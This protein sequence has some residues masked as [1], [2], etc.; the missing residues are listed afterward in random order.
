MRKGL[1]LYNPAAGRYPVRRYVRGI[2]HPL[3]EAGWSI[4]IA[5][6]LSGTHATQTAHQAA[7]EKYDAVFAIGGDGTVGQVASGLLD[8]DTAL[9]VLPAGTTNVWA[10][11]QG[12]KPFS[13]FNWWSLRENAKLLANVD[14]QQVDVGMCND[15][16][17]LLWAGVGLDAHTI[18]KIEPRHRFFKH[19][20]VPHFFATTVWEATFWHGL[21]LRVWTDDK[22]VE[23]HYLVAVATN[24]RHYAGGMSVLSPEALLDDNEMDMWLLSGNSVADALR[25][26]FDLV[27][28]RHL[29]SDQARRLPFHTARVESD[30]AFSIQVDGDPALGS[31]H[32]DIT[33]KHRALKIL[34]PKDALYLLKNPHK[35]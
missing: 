1:L 24:I 3:K 29:T 2:M 7:A 16:P 5:E 33:I 23:G 12:Q 28:G 8:S 35:H 19:I 11:E 18:N 10:I 30:A 13:W 20:S 17:F 21:D 26:F 32:A 15:Q 6:T 9:A 31:S 25:H 14:V 34:M 27:A 4:E 22:L